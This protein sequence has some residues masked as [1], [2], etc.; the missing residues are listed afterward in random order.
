MPAEYTEKSLLKYT[1]KV[2]EMFKNPKNIG[3][4]ENPTVT[5]DEGDIQCGDMFR[6]FLKIENNKIVDAKFLS[7][8]CLPPDEYVLVYPGEWKRIS[9]L[10]VGEATIDSDGKRNFVA[11]TSARDY[12]GNLLKIVPFVSTFNSFSLTPEHPVLCVKREWL[13]SSRKSGNKCVWLRVDKEELPSVKPKFIKAKYLA[14][15]DYLIFVPNSKTEDSK[16]YT[17]DIMKLL[18]FYISEGYTTANDRILAFAFNREETGNIS[19]VKTLL[20]RVTNKKPKCR[21]R[22]NVAEV[23]ICS[24]KWAGF[25]VS[26]GGKYATGKKLAEEVLLLPFK[27]QWEMIKTYLKGDGSVYRMKETHSWVYRIDTRSK[28]LAIQ[29]QEILARGG[30]LSYIK[31]SKRPASIIDGRKIRSNTNYNVAFQLKRKRKI[32]VPAKGYFLVPIRRVEKKNYIGKV[33]NFEVTN[34]PHSYLVRGFAVHNCA[35]NIAT[36]AMTT[37]L[38]KGR[39]VEEAEKMKITEISEALGGLP[40]LKM[41]CAVLAYKTLKKALAEYRKIQA[42]SKGT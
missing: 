22:G 1:E 32:V 6:M 36:G 29:T 10:G 31:K 40:A 20:E 34:E 37:E 4:M 33:Y 12:N 11:E 35:A 39:T 5:A 38:V 14:E 42:G 15:G 26:V 41:H 18:G 24:T 21:V 16:K 28:E 27:K 7:Y 17:T 19:E 23:Y 9:T 30:I 3:E 25:F 13:D 8:G 2:M